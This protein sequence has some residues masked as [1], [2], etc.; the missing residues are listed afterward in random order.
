MENYYDFDQSTRETAWELSKEKKYMTIIIKM[1]GRAVI[2]TSNILFEK[3]I[4]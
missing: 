2:N 1:P 3:N 4:K